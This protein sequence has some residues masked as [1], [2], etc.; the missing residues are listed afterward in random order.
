MSAAS[1]NRAEIGGIYEWAKS[2]K[3][4]SGVQY[5]EQEE[6]KQKCELRKMGGMAMKGRMKV[7]GE[8]RNEKQMRV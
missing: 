6:G 7:W 8:K 2:R 3:S 1:L 4:T 5:T